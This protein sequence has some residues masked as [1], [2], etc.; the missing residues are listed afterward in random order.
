MTNNFE[1]G[2]ISS[3]EEISPSKDPSKIVRIHEKPLVVSRSE[4]SSCDEEF[5]GKITMDYQENYEIDLDNLEMKKNQ[6]SELEV[7]YD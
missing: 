7:R 1:K 6:E 4:S 5:T 3:L 2:N